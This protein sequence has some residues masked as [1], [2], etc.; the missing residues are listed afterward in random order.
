MKPLKEYTPFTVG[1]HFEDTWGNDLVTTGGEIFQ[2]YQNFWG[3]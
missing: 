3:L 2:V 1:E